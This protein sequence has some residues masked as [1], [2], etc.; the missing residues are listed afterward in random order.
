MPR[1]RKPIEAPSTTHHH[2][3]ATS[4]ATLGPPTLVSPELQQLFDYKL[5]I[6]GELRQ[7]IERAA[8]AHG[9]SANRE[10]IRRLEDSFDYGPTK[11]LEAIARDMA[12]LWGRYDKLFRDLG[13]RGDLIRAAEVLA[14][15]VAQLPAAQ[16]S[17]LKEAIQRVQAAAAVVDFEAAAAMRRFAT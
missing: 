15:A 11:E 13:T 3:T 12:A 4:L 2:P 7:R 16:K 5:R 9:T 6:S 14:E 17:P 8:E 1:K 10:M